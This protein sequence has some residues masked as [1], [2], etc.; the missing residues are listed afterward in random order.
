M[1]YRRDPA[2]RARRWRARRALADAAA[3]VD[4]VFAKYETDAS[5]PGCA[6]AVAEGGKPVL[7][8]RLRDVRPRARDAEHRGHRVR[9]GLGLEAVH[10]GGG[11]AAGSRRQAVPRRS[12]P[13]VH[14]GAAR[15]RGAAHHPPDADPHQRPARLGRGGRGGGLAARLPR[16]HPRPRA[17]GAEPP[18]RAQLPERDGV[19]LQ[20]QRLQPRRDPRLPRRG[21]AFRRVHPRAHLRAR[22]A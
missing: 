4:K 12:G 10:G 21:Q 11:D 7:A 19:L 6:V 22:W 2:W 5:R 1:A 15:L 3:R 18:E 20:Q 14:P 9:G 16:A 13:Q 17:R 8:A